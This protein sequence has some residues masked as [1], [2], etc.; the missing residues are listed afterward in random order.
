MSGAQALSSRSV[1]HNVISK[2]DD[3]IA[4]V[5][6]QDEVP[7]RSVFGDGTHVERKSRLLSTVNLKVGLKAGPHFCKDADVFNALSGFDSK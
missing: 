7:V 5:E 2:R 4:S 1:P 6:S 3:H